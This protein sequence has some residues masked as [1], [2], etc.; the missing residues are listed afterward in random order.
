MPNFGETVSFDQRRAINLHGDADHTW[1][2]STVECP[3]PTASPHSQH[4]WIYYSYQA[5]ESSEQK[6]PSSVRMQ[7]SPYFLQKIP[8]HM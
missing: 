7:K 4:A 2:L 1:R 6:N 3:G 5:T 8:I